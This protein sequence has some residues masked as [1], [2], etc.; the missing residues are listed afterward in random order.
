MLDKSKKSG[1]IKLIFVGE[2]KKNI[3][4]QKYLINRLISG[5]RYLFLDE[6]FV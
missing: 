1:V 6:I 3:F 5:N 4:L 2:Y